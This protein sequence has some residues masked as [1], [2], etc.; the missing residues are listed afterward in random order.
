MKKYSLFSALFSILIL[1]KVQAHAN[2]FDETG[3]MQVQ[4]LAK[5][6]KRYSCELKLKGEQKPLM[7]VVGLGNFGFDKTRHNVGEEV[8]KR[9]EYFAR[10]TFFSAPDQWRTYLAKDEADAA[11]YVE[12]SGAS[13]PVR[14]GLQ[15]RYR[16]G[17]TLALPHATSEMQNV[18][19]LHPHYDINESGF[20][21]A[22]IAQELGLKPQQILVLVDDINLER[23][24]LVLSQGKVDGKGDGHNGLKSIN[25]QVGD[26]SYY[27][28]RIGVS[29]PKKEGVDTDRIDWVLGTL[30]AEDRANLLAD[31]KIQV[32]KK[33]VENLQNRQLP[34]T[35]LQK[36]QAEANS[37]LKILN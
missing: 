35:N 25:Q 7:V 5:L 23:N 19:F 1:S 12:F 24:Q 9:L 32:L 20:F 18:I 10:A 17:G 11:D 14:D 26:G 16:I 30:P 21:V 37:L 3:P 27:R 34:E 4:T 29:N 8:L 15:I 2:E 36:S 33:L 13:S 31:E 22:G 28:L 6:A